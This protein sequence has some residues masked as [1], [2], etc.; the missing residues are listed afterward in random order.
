MCGVAGVA[1]AAICKSQVAR[2]HATPH[3]PPLLVS[4]SFFF[5]SKNFIV[6]ERNLER[7][8]KISTTGGN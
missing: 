7:E 4:L 3:L 1:L 6:L 8:S 2:R 5:F